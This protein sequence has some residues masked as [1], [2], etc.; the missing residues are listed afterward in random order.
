MDE[1]HLATLDIW[2][3]NSLMKTLLQISPGFTVRVIDVEGGKN[4]R[5]KLKQYGIYPGDCLRLLRKAPLG[6]PLLVECNERE[7]ALGRGIADKI[8]VELDNC[9]SL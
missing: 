8:I 2:D 9:E 5:S 6:G 4:L 7:I 1:S 3:I